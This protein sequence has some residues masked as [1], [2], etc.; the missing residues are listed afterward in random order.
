MTDERNR[1]CRELAEQAMR[2]QTTSGAA[3]LLAIKRHIEGA[4]EQVF[5]GTTELWQ[6]ADHLAELRWMRPTP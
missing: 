4:P 6:V 2:C 3:L 5:D 1:L